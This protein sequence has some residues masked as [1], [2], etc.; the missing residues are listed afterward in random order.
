MTLPFPLFWLSLATF[1]AYISQARVQLK[2]QLLDYN[3][4]TATSNMSATYAAAH[5]NAGSLTHRVR[6]GIKLASS[7]IPVG[8]LVC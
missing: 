2:L 8:F 5:S 6:P 1:V 7:W 3:T 4:A